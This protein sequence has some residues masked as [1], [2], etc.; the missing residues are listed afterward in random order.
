ME[1]KKDSTLQY[2]DDISTAMWRERN[3]SKCILM[4]LNKVKEAKI[5]LTREEAL[6]LR[7]AM[8]GT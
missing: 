8:L 4:L 1:D 2:I 5:K 3:M 6:L 7:K